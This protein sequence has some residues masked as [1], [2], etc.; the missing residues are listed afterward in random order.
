LNRGQYGHGSGQFANNQ[1]QGGR[2]S[3]RD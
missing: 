3:D 2:G 1:N